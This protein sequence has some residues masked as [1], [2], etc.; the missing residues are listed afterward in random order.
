[1][2][3]II[4]FA[5]ENY[6]RATSLS[7]LKQHVIG[8]GSESKVPP[9]KIPIPDDYRLP[10]N[11]SSPIGRKANAAIVILGKSSSVLRL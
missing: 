10:K 2:H 9:Y 8:T 3:Y 6:G 7:T 4:S 11:V 1:L 5:N